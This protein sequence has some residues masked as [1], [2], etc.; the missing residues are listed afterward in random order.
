MKTKIFISF[1]FGCV[2]AM[3]LRAQDFHLTQYD[4][5]SMYLNP[6]L[7]GNYLGEDADYKISSVYRTQ[8]RP[9][10]SRPYTTY[11]VGYDMV[12]KKFGLGGYLLDNRSGG[13]NFNTLNFQLS[14]SYF[15][16]DPKVS[17]HL[18]NVGLQT[19]LFYKTFNFSNML[20]E[21]QYDYSTSQLNPGISSGEVLQRYSRTN[22]DAN[23]G[24]FYKYRDVTKKYWPFFGFSIFH[25][26]MPME[27]F[28]TYKSRLPMRFNVQGG[29]D[30]LINETWKVTPM[31][32]YMNQ[33]RAWELNIGGL[34]YYKLN[35]GA[36]ANKD[37]SYHL[38]FGLN[39]RVKDAFMLQAG[40]KKD[41]FVLRMSYDINTSYLNAYTN[42]RGGFE[43]TLQIMG[44]KGVSPF[45]SMASF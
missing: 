16:T 8:W 17:P 44:K 26:N 4:A 32:L 43:I 10:A 22:F 37:V 25:A 24:V 36:N 18:L 41:N 3:Q 9:L 2:I 38:I 27:T 15:I 40:V 39:Y 5:F 6:A 29:C 11:G 19:G 30:F 14:A 35:S 20:F 7:T 21:S 28:T 13:P 12:H 31:I 1:F 45:K 42:G 33:A 34:A 23:V